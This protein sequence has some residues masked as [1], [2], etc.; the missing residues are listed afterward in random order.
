MQRSMWAPLVLLAA[1]AAAASPASS[2]PPQA[3]GA[4][5]AASGATARATARIRIVAGV[6]FGSG[7]TVGGA[8]AVVRKARLSDADGVERPA[9]ILE[10]Q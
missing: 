10:F 5:Q 7:K 6:S 9:E 2:P 1:T 3:T 8:A 4:Y